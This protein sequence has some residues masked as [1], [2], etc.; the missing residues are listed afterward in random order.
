MFNEHGINFFLDS[1]VMIL[2]LGISAG[3]LRRCAETLPLFLEKRLPGSSCSSVL[4]WGGAWREKVSGCHHLSKECLHLTEY[5]TCRQSWSSWTMF[6][7]KVLRALV[8]GAI[9]IGWWTM[10][11]VVGIDDTGTVT[12]KW[13]MCDYRWLRL[14]GMIEIYR[15]SAYGILGSKI[16]VLIVIICV[17]V[18]STQQFVVVFKPLA[19]EKEKNLRLEPKTGTFTFHFYYYFRFKLWHRSSEKSSFSY[20][21]N[22]A[23]QQGETNRNFTQQMYVAG[24]NRLSIRVAISRQPTKVDS[25][26]SHSPRPKPMY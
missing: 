13:F 1:Q 11:S 8:T 7:P 23:D 10:F 18:D 6:F 3:R 5:S 21:V 2:S 15:P 17:T 22:W 20:G 9:V 24:V 26:C 4:V 16:C 19:E 14:G 12:L 25:R